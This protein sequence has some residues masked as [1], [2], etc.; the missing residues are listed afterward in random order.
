MASQQFGPGARARRFRL[1]VEGQ[2]FPTSGSFYRLAHH[3]G[4]SPRLE[5][6]PLPIPGF[7]DGLALAPQAPDGGHAGLRPRLK[8]LCFS[9]RPSKS[10]NRKPPAG[11]PSADHASAFLHSLGGKR[12][13]LLSP[14]TGIDRCCRKI[15]FF[16]YRSG[17]SIEMHR[18]LLLKQ[19]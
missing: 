12:K 15:R 10:D 13:L 1:V 17:L 6:R 7:D 11:Q 18:Q 3:S 8:S 5:R 9:A 2:N 14:S 16:A 19:S 4:I